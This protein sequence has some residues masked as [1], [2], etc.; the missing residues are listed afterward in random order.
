MQTSQ[1]Q[2]DSVH[3]SLYQVPVYNQNEEA[4]YVEEQGEISTP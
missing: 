4:K 1:Q 2:I 3:A